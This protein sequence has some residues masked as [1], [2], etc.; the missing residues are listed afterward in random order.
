MLYECNQH[1]RLSTLQ[2]IPI[3]LS[4]LPLQPHSDMAAAAAE[5]QTQAGQDP[6]PNG[7]VTEACP[8]PSSPD[9]RRNGRAV[10][11]RMNGYPNGTAS[12]KHSRDDDYAD[13]GSVSSETAVNNDLP[14][15]PA[16]PEPPAQALLQRAQTAAQEM[17]GQ[18]RIPLRQKPPM[19]NIPPGYRDQWSGKSSRPASIVGSQSGGSDGRR[20]SV[21]MANG[22][23]Q[24]QQR[25]IDQRA[26][27]RPQSQGHS[28]RSPSALI[29]SNKPRGRQ[30]ALS[31]TYRPVVTQPAIVQTAGAPDSRPTAHSPPPGPN[32]ATAATPNPKPQTHQ[33][34][35]P[36]PQITRLESP[37]IPKSVLQPLEQK[38]HE[39][40][41]LMGETRDEMDHLDA[42]LRRLDERRR[43]A[44]SRFLEA[45]AKHDDYE[46]RHQDVSR[47]LRGE[48]VDVSP[49]AQQQPPPQ[50]Q[51]GMGVHNQIPRTA[52]ECLERGQSFDGRPTSAPGTKHGWRTTRLGTRDRI[53]LS[54]FGRN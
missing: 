21:T 10:Q 30:A 1:R 22:G 33:L 42:E 4:Y 48:L 43:Q 51:Q 41:R 17:P 27:G 34:P 38:I 15:D 37:S 39:Y 8:L 14:A 24:Q 23:Q 20:N 40:D 29:W 53:R 50:Q 6:N 49:A 47:A 36:P 46:R 26:N 44:E 28:P 3:T 31:P 25:H 35:P 13:G 7:N 54:L 5:R 19:A 2:H 9:E 11:P 12:P 52:E 32:T 16:A 45:K 18:Q